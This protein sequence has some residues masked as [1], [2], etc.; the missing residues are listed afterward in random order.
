MPTVQHKSRKLSY[1]RRTGRVRR[2]LNELGFRTKSDYRGVGQ[3]GADG[4]YIPVED[5]RRFVLFVRTADYR[6]VFSRDTLLEIQRTMGTFHGANPRFDGVVDLKDGKWLKS[7]NS[8][9]N[10]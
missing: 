10:S 3:P 9:P 4:F 5:L 7:P 6:L 2:V 8:P 1:A